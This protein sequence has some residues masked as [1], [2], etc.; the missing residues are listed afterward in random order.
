MKIIIN[1]LDVRKQR[2]VLNGQYSSWASVKGGVSQASV[3][4]PLFS[5]NIY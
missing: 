3:L 2:F 1:F 5:L 4:V